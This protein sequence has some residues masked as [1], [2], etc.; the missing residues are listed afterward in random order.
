MR[1]ANANRAHTSYVLGAKIPFKKTGLAR[2]RPRRGEQAAD[3]EREAARK[4]GDHDR[5]RGV[6]ERIPCRFHLFGVARGGQVLEGRDKNKDH[7]QD[8]EE[9]EEPAHDDVA[10]ETLE[11]GEAGDRRRRSRDRKGRDRQS[12][13]RNTRE[14]RA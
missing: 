10:D 5:N 6:H 7:G 11:T 14:R 2:N 9:R 1:W 13:C 8:D 3:N 4:E 12:R